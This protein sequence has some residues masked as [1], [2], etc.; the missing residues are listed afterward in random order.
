[1]LTVI[2]P[3]VAKYVVNLIQAKIKESTIISETTKNQAGVGRKRTSAKGERK[4]KT[5]REE[6]QRIDLA[7]GI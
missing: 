6:G 4:A 3:V 7:E 1:M 2:L 5:Q